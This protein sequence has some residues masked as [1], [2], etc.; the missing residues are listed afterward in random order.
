MVGLGGVVVG[1][2]GVLVAGYEA[3]DA[4]GCDAAEAGGPEAVDGVLV[5][6]VVEGGDAADPAEVVEGFFGVAEGVVEVAAYGEV[7]EG[8]A[9][10]YGADDVPCV[11]G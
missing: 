1:A 9:E 6:P 7:A 3:L 5:E 10:G 2:V 11:L 4:D 8:F